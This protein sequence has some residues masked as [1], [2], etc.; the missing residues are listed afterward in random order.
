[1]WVV[2][3]GISNPIHQ[4]IVSQIIYRD[5]KFYSQIYMK[6][7]I[8]NSADVISEDIENVILLVISKVYYI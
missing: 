5:I 2:N 4:C 8:F 6:F 1:M 7:N 3:C